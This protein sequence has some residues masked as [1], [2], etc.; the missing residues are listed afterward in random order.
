MADNGGTSLSLHHHTRASFSERLNILAYVTT[1]FYFLQNLVFQ[2][3]SQ[4]ALFGFLVPIIQELL[5]LQCQGKGKKPCAFQTHP[6]S[7][8]ISLATFVLYCLVY[9]VEPDLIQLYLA[10][11]R[12]LAHCKELLAWLCPLSLASIL[13]PDP[14]SV[15]LYFLYV[16]VFAG[17]AFWGRVEAR[18][19]NRGAILPL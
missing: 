19:R 8:W 1:S 10:L 9:Y 16:L 12:V 15:V 18:R 14:V 5:K 7:C 4:E 6:K 17:K 2:P 3:H 13:L 11:T